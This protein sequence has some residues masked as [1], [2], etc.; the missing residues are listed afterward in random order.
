MKKNVADNGRDLGERSLDPHFIKS[1]ASHGLTGEEMKR[2]F[3]EIRVR[4]WK[5]DENR[6]RKDL[7]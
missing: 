6:V 1:L 3:K 7:R 5:K 2:I 4:W